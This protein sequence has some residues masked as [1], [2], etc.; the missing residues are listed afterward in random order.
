MY[1]ESC[2][3]PALVMTGEND[4]INPPEEGEKVAEALP[5]AAFKL[6]P[7][8]EHEACEGN[9]E[10]VFEQTDAFLDGPQPGRD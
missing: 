7:G 3:V 6:V 5:D 10:F 2:G 8:A 9:P 4:F 1:L